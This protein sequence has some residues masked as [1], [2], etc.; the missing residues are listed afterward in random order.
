MRLSAG[1]G[2]AHVLFDKVVGGYDLSDN[3]VRHDLLQ[4]RFVSLPHFGEVSQSI[5]SPDDPDQRKQH[6]G[7]LHRLSHDSLHVPIVF[8]Y[9]VLIGVVDAHQREAARITP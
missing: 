1:D 6:V 3:G 9:D 4:K 2:L 8:F 5:G 7:R